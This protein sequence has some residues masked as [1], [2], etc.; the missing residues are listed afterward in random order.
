MV[1]QIY[2]VK[3]VKEALEVIDAGADH[4]G[5]VPGSC[6]IPGGISNRTAS[7]IFKA[8]GSRAVKVA[9]TIADDPEEMIEMA[10]ELHPDIVHIS[11]PHFTATPEF[12]KRFRSLCGGV[13]IMQ[14]VPVT[15]HECI[16]QARYLSGFVD[17]ILL[18]SVS[19]NAAGIGASGV[20]NDWGI[21]R[22]IVE[23][24]RVP[25]IL[26]GGLCKDNVADAIRAV[27]PWGVD[28]MT[29][30]DKILPSGESVKD[31]EKVAAF[32][33]AARGVAL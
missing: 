23:A 3:S 27:R 26:A 28:S 14:A 29:R 22:K 15:G 5:L 31:I 21:G 20:T 32:C 12:A 10:Q 13:K 7:E 30:T 2:S 17:Y 8:V 33:K 16:D 25:V 1:C 18:D 4:I 6:D 19:S 9:L 24:S 11:G